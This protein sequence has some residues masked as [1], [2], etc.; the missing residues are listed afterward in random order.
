MAKIDATENELKSQQFR[1]VTALVTTG[2]VP[3]AAEA[4]GVSLRTLQ[5]WMALPTFRQELQNAE[6]EVLRTAA[7]RLGTLAQKAL[8]VLEEVMGNKKAADSPR[9][10]AANVVLDTCMRWREQ[11][12]IEERVQALE[13][14]IRGRQ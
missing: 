11:V 1:A 12:M 5:R 6:A 7:R 8:G 9:I 14:H 2:S 10:R 4:A 3:T 13:Q